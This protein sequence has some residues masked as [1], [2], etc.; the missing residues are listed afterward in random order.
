MSFCINTPCLT[1]VICKTVGKVHICHF[2][3]CKLRHETD[4]DG[5][6]Q[7]GRKCMYNTSQ[8]TRSNIRTEVYFWFCDFDFDFVT[9]FTVVRI[10]THMKQGIFMQEDIS[11]A[12]YLFIFI[13]HLRTFTC[14]SETKPF[15]TRLYGFFYLK[16]TKESP[17]WVWQHT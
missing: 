11:N 17:Y 15:R 3:I 5:L 6:K 12:I 9:L 16:W 10:V 2:K 14:I 1:W 13:K 4:F 8:L 7:F